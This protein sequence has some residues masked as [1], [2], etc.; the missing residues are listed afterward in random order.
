M[1]QL[2]EWV[3]TQRKNH[4]KKSLKKVRGGGPAMCDV[5]CGAVCAVV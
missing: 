5:V 3:S 2:Y 4:R 1:K